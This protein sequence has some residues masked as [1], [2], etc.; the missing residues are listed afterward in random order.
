MGAL[1]HCGF[2]ASDFASGVDDDSGNGSGGPG[3]GPETDARPDQVAPP[4]R[5]LVAT[6]VV[7]GDAHSCAL[8]PEGQVYCWGSNE[9]GQLGLP[10]DVAALSVP[11]QVELPDG[12]RVQGLAAGSQHT[13]AIT[14]RETLICWGRNDVGQLGRPASAFA[15]PGAIVPPPALATAAFVAVAAGRAHTCA[16]YIQPQVSDAGEGDAGPPAVFR[17]SC[18]GDNGNLQLAQADVAYSDLPT[19]VRRG[20]NAV[21]VGSP[22]NSS[23]ALGSDFSV[24]S[25]RSSDGYRVQA[26]GRAAEGQLAT[27]PDSGPRPTPTSVLTEDG[28]TLDGVVDVASGAAHSC[29]AVRVGIAPDAG[30]ASDADSDAGESDAGPDEDGGDASAMPGNSDLQLV[31]WGRNDRGELARDTASPYEK[32][33]LAADPPRRASVLVVGGR[34]TCLLGE[35]Q[36]RCAGANDQGQLG[37]GVADEAAH[38]ALAPVRGLDWDIVAASMGA[39]HACALVQTPIPGIAQVA[40]WGDNSQG[41]LGDGIGLGT[42]YADAASSDRYRRTLPVFVAPAE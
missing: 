36:L 37:L 24:A 18:W 11:R 42:G 35:G 3:I 8:D 22:A 5:G 13:C 15:A 4:P 32:P 30:G 23:L 12:A 40:C 31:C 34:V 33:A 1:A 27:D 21:V 2:S 25:L 38:A 39:R 17:L 10:L 41:Q 9:Y 29:V 19:D 20:A 6:Q 28:G 14:D 26:W 16:V 7:T